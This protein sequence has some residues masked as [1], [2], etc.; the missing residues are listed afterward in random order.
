MSGRRRAEAEAPGRLDVMGGIADYSGA[1]VLE[2]PIRQT[3]RV[4]VEALASPRLLFES[5]GYATVDVKDPA[6]FALLDGRPAYVEVRAGLDALE[7]PAWVRY[8]LG[9]LIVLA[10]AHAFARAP[11]Y[12]F[13]IESTVP[14]AERISSTSKP[15]VRPAS[16]SLIA[17]QHAPAQP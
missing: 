1:L 4:T 7:L 14:S 3:T 17:R 10:R 8:P 9:C 5:R 13:R 16:S 2:T 12:A 11:G 6:L 15:P